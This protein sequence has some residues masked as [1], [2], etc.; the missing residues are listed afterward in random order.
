MRFTFA[1]RLR[2]NKGTHYTLEMAKVEETK[3]WVRVLCEKAR[4]LFLLMWQRALPT[5]RKPGEQFRYL[6]RNESRLKV[7][8]RQADPT[9]SSVPKQAAAT[10]RV[11]WEVVQSCCCVLWIDN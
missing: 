6:S 3:W 5:K 11:A 4:N 7:R 8:L 9:M 2:L 1:R 10:A